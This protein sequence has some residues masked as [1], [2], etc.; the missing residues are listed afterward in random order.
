V[1]P[2]LRGLPSRNLK[3]PSP[4]RIS[5]SASHEECG[6]KI[7]IISDL[8]GSLTALEQVLAQL[9]P[10][11]LI[12]ICCS[13]I[14]SITGRAIRCRRGMILPPWRQGSTSWP[15]H[16]GGAWQLRFGGGPDAAPLPHHGALQPAAGGWALV[17]QPRSSL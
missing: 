4:P 6:M 2:A 3:G 9:A 15:P 13:G 1:D 5:I 14:C 11:S 16:H 8:H 7:A 12:T 10:G 17:R